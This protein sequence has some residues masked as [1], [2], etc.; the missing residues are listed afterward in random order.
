MSAKRK[1]AFAPEEI[2]ELCFAKVLEYERYEDTRQQKAQFKRKLRA[3]RDE[4]L[5]ALNAGNVNEEG[6]TDGGSTD[7][8]D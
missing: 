8:A 2:V 6:E 4:I 7:T 3:Y 1:A 5:S